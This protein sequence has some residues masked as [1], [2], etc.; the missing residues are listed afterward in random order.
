M[1]QTLAKTDIVDEI[2][3]HHETFVNG[4]KDCVDAALEIGR[5]LNEQKAAMAHGQFLPWLESNVTFIA[6]RTCR[7]WMQ[8]DRNRSKLASVANLSEAYQMLEAPK[9]VDDD[10]GGDDEETKRQAR[11]R[12]R[13][14]K[15]KKW[16]DD[17][18]ARMRGDA[19]DAPADVAGD[20]V[21]AEVKERNHHVGVGNPKGCKAAPV[22]RFAMQFAEMAICQIERIQEDDTDRVKA[23]LHVR[24]YI[25]SQL[26]RKG[27]TKST[28]RVHIPVGGGFS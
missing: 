1:T 16:C 8:L 11:Q 26:Q 20:V 4:V 14:L 28:R 2:R 23:L 15:K 22:A 6:S 13:W 18:L 21:E 24:E 25:D 10:G 3:I 9:A 7:R 27:G 5:I 12:Q 17:E 19:V